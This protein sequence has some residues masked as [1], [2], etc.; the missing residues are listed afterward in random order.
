MSA[1]PRQGESAPPYLAEPTPQTLAALRTAFT[2]SGYT[3]RRIAAALGP[4]PPL[5]RTR[6]EV[7][8]RRLQEAGD[9]GALARLFRLGD[10]LSESEAATALSPADLG[11]L[12]DAGILQSSGAEVSAGIEVTPYDGL[13]LA[14]DRTDP[15]QRVESWHVLFGSASRTLAA[16]TIRRPVGRALDLGTG[17][18]V[19]ALLAARH[20]ER[21]VATD[22]SE[23]ALLFTRINA[24]LND[25]RNLE[26]R[27]GDLFEVVAGERFGLIVSNPPFVVSPDTDLVFRDSELPADEISRLV[28]TQAAD[29]LED[30]GHATV[31]C[32]W[33]CPVD[34]HWST[35]IRSWVGPGWDVLLLQFTCA[36]PL[37]YAAMWTDELDRWLRHYR[38]E[39]I[40][41]ISTG[42]AVVRRASPGGRVVALQSTGAPAVNAG[43][44][45]LRILDAQDDDLGDLLEGRFRLADHRLRQDATYGDGTYSIELTGVSI[46]GSPLNARVETDALHVLARLDSSAPLAEIVDRAARET[47]LDRARIEEATVTTVRRLYARGFLIREA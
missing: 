47:G 19:Q 6:R 33:I 4:R 42:A 8:R 29:H 22:V 44:Q 34:D 31:L 10:A 3:H 41:W 7:Y 46:A 40:E 27:C 26:C 28:I 43:E 20:A 30:G 21:V 38:D 24:A 32:S 35:P 2:R 45:F 16:L 25:V 37:E 15:A 5:P 9:L 13:L 1:R 14:H 11:D 23:R 36:H 12:V 39:G 18:G 17:C